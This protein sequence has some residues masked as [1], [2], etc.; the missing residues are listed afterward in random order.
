[1]GFTL[2]KLLAAVIVT[3]TCLS[4]LF[5]FFGSALPPATAN[6]INVSA[7]DAQ[8]TFNSSIYSNINK[9][10][11]GSNKNGNYTGSFFVNVNL[12]TGLAFVPAE[13]GQVVLSILNLPAVFVTLLSLG[14]AYSPLPTGMTALMIKG[15][16]EFIVV[17]IL[18]TFFSGWLKFN[19]LG[20][21]D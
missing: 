13:F 6:A 16:V 2:Y 9:T 21:V 17:I 11:I 18:I 5:P 10:V 8:Q 4:L 3:A 7:Y 14:L 12:L 1:M 19:L 20:K 15:V